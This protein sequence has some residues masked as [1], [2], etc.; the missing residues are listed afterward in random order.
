[1]T[2]PRRMRGLAFKDRALLQFRFETYQNFSGGLILMPMN[3][4]YFLNIVIFDRNNCV[5]QK[6]GLIFEKNQDTAY[7]R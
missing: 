4:L 6:P 1:M 7:R 5:C 2:V 3:L